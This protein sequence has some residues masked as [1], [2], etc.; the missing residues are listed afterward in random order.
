MQA[1]ITQPQR[2]RFFLFFI[3]KKMLRPLC[4][5][6]VASKTVIKGLKEGHE[7]H[8]EGVH[9]RCA[10]S[11]CGTSVQKSAIQFNLILFN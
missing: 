9:L 11:A 6:Q 4:S 2:C 1:A 3:K 10:T 5:V 8:N 7:R